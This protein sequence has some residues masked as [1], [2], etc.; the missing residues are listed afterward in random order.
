[1]VG[2]MNASVIDTPAEVVPAT[3]TVRPAHLTPDVT[4]YLA[5]HRA[6]RTANAQLVSGLVHTLHYDPRRVAALRRWFEGYAAELRTHHRIEDDIIFPALAERSAEFVALSSSLDV[7]HHRLDEIMDAL[8]DILT[9]WA[10]V[11]DMR[12]TGTLREDAIFYAV[13][14][15][16]LLAV[17][18]DIEDTRVIP[19]LQQEFTAEEY[20]A[21]DAQAAKAISLK[22]AFWTVP[23]IV[24]TF[25][26]ATLEKLWAEAPAMLKIIHRLSRRSYARLTET[27][28]AGSAHAM[29]CAS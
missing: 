26:A 1:M 13:E 18:L 24:A 25:D 14:L 19:L 23:W 8:S 21:F 22:H 17:H 16:D 11:T 20:A 5:I 7:D 15:R 27:A 3:E 9:R 10:A 28:F 2:D 6:M 12:A 29:G 4:A